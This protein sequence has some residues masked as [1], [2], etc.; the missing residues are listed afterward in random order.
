MNRGIAIG[1]MITRILRHDHIFLIRK[2]KIDMIV[3]HRALIRFSCLTILIVIFIKNNHATK[4]ASQV[5]HVLTMYH[6]TH[7]VLS[8]PTPLTC[9]SIE[10]NCG[11][12]DK[13]KNDIDN[14]V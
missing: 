10:G 13:A 6:L 12:S 1:L 8:A 14:I 7:Y 2:E 3:I 4:C 11:N 9:F 5:T